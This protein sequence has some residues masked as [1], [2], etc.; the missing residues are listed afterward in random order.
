MMF[1]LGLAMLCGMEREMGVSF[2]FICWRVRM[3]CG[4]ASWRMEARLCIA[5]IDQPNLVYYGDLV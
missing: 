5:R 4:R 2:L 1:A 3:G